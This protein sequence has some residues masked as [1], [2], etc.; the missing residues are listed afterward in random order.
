MACIGERP[1]LPEG[2]EGGSHE[3]FGRFGKPD[4]EFRGEGRGIGSVGSGPNVL[5]VIAEYLGIIA[6]M[7]IAVYYLEKWLMKRKALRK[8]PLRN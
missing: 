3:G 1:E 8:P 7:V 5:G 2:D 4:G 6:V